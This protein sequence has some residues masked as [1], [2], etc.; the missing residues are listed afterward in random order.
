MIIKDAKCNWWFWWWSG[1]H[2]NRSCGAGGSGEHGTFFVNDI[3]VSGNTA[4]EHGY[5]NRNSSGETS[6]GNATRLPVLLVRNQVPS[7]KG[8]T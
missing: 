8:Y 4:N 2:R 1:S 3:K 5:C 6:G 7:G